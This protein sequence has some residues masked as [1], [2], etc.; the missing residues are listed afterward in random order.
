[1]NNPN[2]EVKEGGRVVDI[3]YHLIDDTTALVALGQTHDERGAEALLVDEALVEPAVFTHIEA[4]V[5]GIDHEG[6][7]QQAFLLEIVQQ[8]PNL[9]VEGVNDLGVVTHIALVLPF[10]QLG[11]ATAGD[12]AL[13]LQRTEVVV[14]APLLVEVAR[15]GD[16]EIV[17]LLALGLRE[18][19]DHALVST[20]VHGGRCL[21]VADKH[22]RVIDDVHILANLHLCF[23]G[24]LAGGIVVMELRRERKGLV[25]VHADILQRRQ[26]CTVTGFVMNE[27]G[28]RL[29]R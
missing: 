6:V 7:V 13:R 20:G 19:P 16:V 1:M 28:E 8:A 15:E 12:T 3:L 24:G 5:G 10:E 21:L 26:P 29:I 9:L 4:L 18:A 11:I 23:A 14:T 27:E 25:L 17:V 2:G 22:L